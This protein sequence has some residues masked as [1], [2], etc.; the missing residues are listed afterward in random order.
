MNAEWSGALGHLVGGLAKSRFVTGGVVCL[1]CAGG[2]VRTLARTPLTA[3]GRF[4]V[5]SS[6]PP[7]LLGVNPPLA[8]DAR[9]VSKSYGTL[10][11]VD[12][13]SIQ[14]APGE[15]YGVLGAQR[16]RQDDVPADALRAHQP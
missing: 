16:R 7:T 10:R 8:V 3:P 9:G 14:V 2:P 12:D 11:A 6:R 15:V 13:I 5:P 4:I 1:P